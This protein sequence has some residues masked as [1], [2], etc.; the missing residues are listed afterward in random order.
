MSRDFSNRYG[1]GAPDGAITI[2]EDA[3]DDLRYAVA[4]IARSVGIG[5]K[6]IRSTVCRVLFVAPNANNW[7]DYPNVW[8][9]VLRLLAD[10][11][12]FKVYD[13][14][15]ALWRSLEYQDESQGLFENELN[16]FFRE[17]GIGW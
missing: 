11:E 1:Y 16:R 5:P 15:E 14:A 3:P 4:E 7:S 17:K 8:E 13:V 2:R 9:E 12:W 6:E 10:C